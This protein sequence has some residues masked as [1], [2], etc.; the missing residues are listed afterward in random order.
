[1]DKHYRITKD[2]DLPFGT[3]AKDMDGSLVSEECLLGITTESRPYLI[4]TDFGNGAPFRFMSK[5]PD[6]LVYM[7]RGTGLRLTI[8]RDQPEVLQPRI[9][10]FG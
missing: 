1:M 2:V 7:Q 5:R 4:T 8:Y 9:G 10:L 3:V 6:R